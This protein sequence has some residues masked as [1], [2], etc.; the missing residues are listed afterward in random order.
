[1]TLAETIVSVWVLL[2]ILILI[3]LAG[4][5]R[6]PIAL[7]DA[8][9]DG[10]PRYQPWSDDTA[11]PVRS[12]HTAAAVLH[13]GSPDQRIFSSDDDEGDDETGPCAR[14]EGEGCPDRGYTHEDFLADK[15]DRRYAQM[16]DEGWR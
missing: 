7:T 2:L 6:D 9:E 5:G 8:A 11:G 16:K 3:F 13:S 14:C 4:L 12:D 15:A 10:P 1:M